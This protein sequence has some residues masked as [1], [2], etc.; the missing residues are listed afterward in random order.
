MSFRNTNQNLQ[1]DFNEFGPWY[2]ETGPN[3]KYIRENV[4]NKFKVP[5]I[6]NNELNNILL[7]HIPDSK[8]DFGSWRG[9]AVFGLD[10][11]I[12]NNIKKDIKILVDEKII[13]HA[14]KT[15]NDKFKPLVIHKLYEPNGYMTKKI[16]NRTKIG[17]NNHI[18]LID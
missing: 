15:L 7:K 10:E 5:E 2:E 3:A 4:F 9:Y 8:N 1:G 6:T 14:Y 18:K 16:A 13:K 11:K 12:F 17:K